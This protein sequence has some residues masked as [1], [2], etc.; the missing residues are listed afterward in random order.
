MD[1]KQR[2]L[3]VS[4]KAPTVSKKASP[5][6]IPRKCPENTLNLPFCLTFRVF[7]PISFAGIPFKS[8][9]RAG[10]LHN[11][12]RAER[13]KWEKRGKFA[14]IETGKNGRKIPKKME[15]RPDFPFFRYFS[16]I[17]PSFDRGKFSTFF[18]SPIFVVRPTFH[19]VAG[20]R[21]QFKPLQA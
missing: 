4:K 12:K 6:H 20:P 19:C 11:G 13:Q 8:C 17:F 15:N 14:P 9:N 2:S 3:T 16:A 1:C 5:P 21:L 7:F 10:L 18:F